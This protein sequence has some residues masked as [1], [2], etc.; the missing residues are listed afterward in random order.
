MRVTHVITRLIV[1]G[2]QENTIA[3]VLGLRAK[4]GMDVNLVAGPTH[5]REGSLQPLV[6]SEPGL[7]VLIPSLVR[8]IRPWSDWMAYRSLVRHFRSRRPLLVHTHSGKAGV[9]GRF[10]AHRARVPL[11]VHS[12]HGPS[13]GDFQGSMANWMFTRAERMAGGYTTHFVV[14]ADAMKQQY[15]KANIGTPEQYTR[16]FSGFRLEPFLGARRDPSFRSELG[17]AEDD[18][19]VGKVARLFELKGHDELLAAAPALIRQCPRIKFLLVGDGPWRERLESETARSEL[20][21][22]FIFTGLIPPEAVPQHLACM[23]VLVHLSRREGLARVLPQALA[24]GIPVVA[25]DCDGAGEVCLD[26]RSGYLVRSGDG[27]LL[28][29]R[30]L[31]LAASPALRRQLGD[32]GRAFVKERFALDRL[33]E[34]QWLLYHRLVEEAGLTVANDER[35]HANPSI[36][37]G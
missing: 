17:I 4:P 14:V 24:V 16:I 33:V 25:A 28:I 19:V 27:E 18:F 5:G 10:A 3:S 21:G 13:F 15:L 34:D 32:F 23:D 1:G 35:P 31:R 29:N 12:I 7:L 20:K 9:L 8:P 11:I 6:A 37:I 2:A 30:L 22:H 36:T 26:D